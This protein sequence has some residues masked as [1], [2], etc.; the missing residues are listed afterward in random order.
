MS[1]N[2]SGCLA[3]FAS[4]A[5]VFVADCKPFVINAARWVKHLSKRQAALSSNNNCVRLHPRFVGQL[6]SNVLLAFYNN[7]ARYTLIALLLFFALPTTIARKIARI[8]VN[9]VKRV[10][11]WAWS[12][13]GYKI[14]KA[15]F[16]LRPSLTN[17]DAPASVVLPLAKLWVRTSINHGSP[18][19]V[20]R[21]WIAKRHV[22]SST[23]AAIVNG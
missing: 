13:V 3:I 15:N 19:M 2:G 22:N 6:C 11:V 1:R 18:N 7:F 8:V 12:H 5:S 4:S 9:A 14:V 16:V 20:K 23:H 10:S 17:G 21:M